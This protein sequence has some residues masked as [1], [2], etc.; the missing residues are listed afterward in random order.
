MGT[1]VGVGRGANVGEGEEVDCETEVA[2]AEVDVITDGAK[3]EEK[4]VVAVGEGVEMLEGMAVEDDDILEEARM[5][6]GVGIG[7]ASPWNGEG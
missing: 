3:L 1:G 4:E 7:S 6:V 2:G 5:T